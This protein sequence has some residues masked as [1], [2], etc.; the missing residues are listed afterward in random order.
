[1]AAAGSSL[2]A[3]TNNSS[4]DDVP[5]W[6]PVHCGGSSATGPTCG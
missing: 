2:R 5:D 6:S 3:L 4:W 1:M